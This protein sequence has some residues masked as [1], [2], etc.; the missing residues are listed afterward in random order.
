MIR[1]LQ[2]SIVDL[3]T[4]FD[5][6]PMTE[7]K[8]ALYADALSDI[9]EDQLSVLVDRIIAT[10]LSS[11]LP[12]PGE[13]KAAW[14]DLLIGPSNPDGSLKWCL[15]EV[16][17]QQ[18]DARRLYYSLDVATRGQFVFRPVVPERF[19]DPVTMET[20]RLIGWESLVDMDDDLRRGLWAKRY[21]EARNIVAMRVASGDSPVAV[22]GNGKPDLKVLK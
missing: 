7:E 13:I 15:A 11:F 19:P 1:T 21:T 20:V 16:V 5:A 22:N 3:G 10:R 17:R 18:D 6:K 14:A 9:P 2:Q 12:T 8:I 4:V